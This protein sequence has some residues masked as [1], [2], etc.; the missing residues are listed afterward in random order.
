MRQNFGHTDI[1]IHPLK[2]NSAASKLSRNSLEI[3]DQKCLALVFIIWPVDKVN[4][5]L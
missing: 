2:E 3:Y 4:L 5:S 1:L